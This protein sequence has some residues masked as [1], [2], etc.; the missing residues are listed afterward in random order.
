MFDLYRSPFRRR[1]IF[2]LAAVALVAF[3]GPAQAFFD[4]FFRG[5]VRTA[6][7]VRSYADPNGDARRVPGHERRDRSRTTASGDVV[8]CVR[9]CDGRH[10]PINFRGGGPEL[11]KA[12]CPASP[13]QTFSGRSIADAHS[14]DGKR[15]S[16]IPSAFVYRQRLVDDCTCN[17]KSPFGLARQDIAEDESLRRGD[18][19]ATQQGFMSYRGDT[20]RYAD[21][22]PLNVKTL[23]PGLRK[24]LADTG[25][26]SEP[27]V[28]AP[29]ETTGVA[30]A[31]RYAERGDQASR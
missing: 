7:S 27:V 12:L 5:H 10:F 23:P 21:F 13:T 28:V 9:L 30:S 18:I 14:A 31:G 3:G 25:I 4:M 20:R 16:D 8:Y 24:K 11:C 15:Y 22:E 26:Q 1:G 29:V 2:V 17:G 19:L 6:P